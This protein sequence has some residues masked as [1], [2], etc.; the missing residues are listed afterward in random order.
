MKKDDVVVVNRFT[1]KYNEGHGKTPQRFLLRYI[2]R[3]GATSALSTGQE[4]QEQHQRQ[5]QI[6]KERTNYWQH[7]RDLYDAMSEDYSGRSFGNFGYVYTNQQVRQQGRLFQRL[8]DAGH[9]IQTMIVSFSTDYLKRL[10]VVSQ[11]FKVHSTKDKPQAVNEVDQIRLRYA[12]NVGLQRYVRQAKFNR[13]IWSGAIQFDRPHVH[14]HILIA[15]AGSLSRSR[16]LSQA[17]QYL[18][19]R[20]KIFQSETHTLIQGINQSL[21]KTQ[22]LQLLHYHL[23]LEHDVVR[24]KTLDVIQREE[25]LSQ[26]LKL[27]R[28]VLPQDNH[29]WQMGNTAKE[30]Q[31]PQKMMRQLVTQLCNQYGDLIGYPHALRVIRQEAQSRQRIMGGQTRNYVKRGINNLQTMMGDAIF[32]RMA[33]EPTKQEEPQ[34][35]RLYQLL[36][37]PLSKAFN[38]CQVNVTKHEERASLYAQALQD[39]QQQYASGQASL[40]SQPMETLWRAELLHEMECADKYR[41]FTQTFKPKKRKKNQRIFKFNR[42]VDQLAPHDDLAYELS[43]LL[44]SSKYEQVL[45][46]PVGEEVPEKAITQYL[47]CGLMSRNMRQWVQSFGQEHADFRELYRFPSNNLLDQRRQV[48]HLQLQ[49]FQLSWQ[50]W[51]QGVVQAKDVIMPPVWQTPTIAPLESHVITTEEYQEKLQWRA[52]AETLN[53]IKQNLRWTSQ[54]QAVVQAEHHERLHNVLAADE[55]LQKTE[56]STTVLEPVAQDIQTETQA[57]QQLSGEQPGVAAV[58]KAVEPAPEMQR[59][60]MVPADEEALSQTIVDELQTLNHDQEQVAACLER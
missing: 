9:T 51:Q 44:V 28:M 58:A 6:L 3:A 35:N 53:A 10:R 12:L 55:Y 49:G 20:G 18:S 60:L 38:L 34:H 30:M 26:Q 54:G 29:L 7:Y 46:H 2:D 17:D 45:Q 22:Q 33:Q 15:D 47:Q 57:L 48:E 50:L 13:P 59:Q 56:Q 4:I 25:S 23:R 52:P 37:S 39:Y 24:D 5:Q 11:N 40:D 32:K 21:V 41:Y 43:R 1:N 19:D 16:R 8:W 31:Q 36:H 42:Q 14:A 27:M